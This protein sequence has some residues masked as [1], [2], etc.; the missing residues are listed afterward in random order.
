MDI[1]AFLIGAI[2]PNK[3]PESLRWATITAV[4]D[5]DSGIYTDSEDEVS[6]DEV[7]RWAVKNPGL[8]WRKHVDSGTGK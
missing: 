8:D 6:E 4:N 1:S 5:D 2:L 7:E 3:I